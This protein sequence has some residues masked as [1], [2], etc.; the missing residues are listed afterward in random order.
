MH[1]RIAGGGSAFSKSGDNGNLRS[2]VYDMCR[3]KLFQFCAGTE[4]QVTPQAVT[5]ALAAVCIHS[6]VSHIARLHGISG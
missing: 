3:M 4:S 1:S 2:I 5:P 6:G